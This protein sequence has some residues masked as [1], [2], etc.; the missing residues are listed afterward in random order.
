MSGAVFCTAQPI[1]GWAFLFDGTTLICRRGNGKK[2]AIV[3]QNDWRSSTFWA[4]EHVDHYFTVLLKC[5]QNN[6][7]V[8]LHIP[9][10]LVYEIR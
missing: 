10:K 9:S 6:E 2:K 3:L 5:W 1:G 7:Q 4:S 8:A